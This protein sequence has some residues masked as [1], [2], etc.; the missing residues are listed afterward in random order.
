ME[1]LIGKKLPEI[2]LSAL[3]GGK[4][5]KINLKDRKG[6][7]TILAFYPADFTFICPTELGAFADLYEEFRK[8]GAEILSVSSDSVYSHKVWKDVSPMA[9]KIQFPMLSDKTGRLCRALGI[10]LEDE[11]ISLRATF[12][13]DPDLQIQAYEV[14]SNNIS[15]NAKEIL[16]KLK[17]AKFVRENKGMVCQTESAKPLKP[18]VKLIG[19]I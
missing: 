15:R 2:E 1:P 19:K 3:S 14:H 9:N 12:I 8:E 11:G 13:I 17:S 6:E 16:R 5:S 7:W 10:Y 18:S 4:L